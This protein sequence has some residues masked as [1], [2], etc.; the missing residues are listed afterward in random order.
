M[1][2]EAV[3][4]RFCIELQRFCCGGDTVKIWCKSVFYI[5]WAGRG[6][7]LMR[8]SFKWCGE[9]TLIYRGAGGA[10]S[11]REESTK[12]G[13]I[14]WG[15]SPLPRSPT[16][17]STMRNPVIRICQKTLE[18]IMLGDFF[19]FDWPVNCASLVCKLCVAFQTRPDTQTLFLLDCIQ[20][21]PI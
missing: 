10:S 9:H 21:C 15:H 11:T 8:D 5:L 6:N 4:Q 16:P 18:L 3:S 20:Y 19:G 1:L 14:G 17:N 2:K 13:Y 7:Q 12:Q